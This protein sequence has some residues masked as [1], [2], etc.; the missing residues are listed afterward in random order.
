M[1]N[2]PFSDVEQQIAVFKG[3]SIE[4]C[5][6]GGWSFTLWYKLPYLVYASSEG[7]NET[8]QMRMIVLV[9]AA[10]ICA[11]SN[12]VLAQIFACTYHQEP[13]QYSHV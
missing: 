13:Q 5:L 12:K 6:I 4:L 11:K 10:R 9:L 7:L 1:L 3:A 2:G 8:V